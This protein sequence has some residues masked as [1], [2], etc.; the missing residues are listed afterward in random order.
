MKRKVF[1]LAV[2]L[3]LLIP[4]TITLAD[5]T[6]TIVET[7]GIIDGLPTD[8]RDYENVEYAVDGNLST[9]A[10]PQGVRYAYMEWK[11]DEPQD[12]YNYYIS[13]S[14]I[15]NNTRVRF[16]FYSENENG[17]QEL[18]YENDI[19]SNNHDITTIEETGMDSVEDGEMKDITAIRLV[20]S[21]LGGQRFGVA[22]FD[23]NVNHINE[24]K[25][26][27][28]NVN[29]LNITTNTN[30]INLSYTI[31]QQYD[32]INFYVDGELEGTT[33]DSEYTIDRLQQNTEYEIRVT[34]TF[35]DNETEGTTETVRTQ[36]EGIENVEN[37]EYEPSYEYIDLTYDL[38]DHELFNYTSVYV[39]GER[40]IDDYKDGQVT[41][42]GLEDNTTHEIAFK[43]YYED[44]LET[45]EET[46]RIKTLE[47]EVEPG[48]Q[49]VKNLQADNSE[50]GRI[51]LSWDNP[52]YYFD[53]AIIYRKTTS[54]GEQSAFNPFQ[55]YTVHAD[56]T[57]SDHE[58]IFE[59]NGTEFSDLT[60]EEGNEYEYKV[61][62]EYDGIESE[63]V[64][65]QTTAPTPPIIDISD[66]SLPFGAEGLLSSSSAI[67]KLIGSF[68]LLSLA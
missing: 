33:T 61:T 13:A 12:I 9:F 54:E 49:E 29:D 17:E 50:E 22:H 27:L 32:H 20:D 58:P 52:E 65:V 7:D 42:E 53:K 35:G 11:F 15:S 5:E 51:D 39:D 37:I 31:P 24:Q 66:V 67:L 63:G 19:Y 41:V 34:S 48:Q 14:T 47:K 55:T 64:Y 38:P 26:D 43:S 8:Y 36:L 60:V 45:E 25:V 59:T 6:V 40:Y 30:S 46:I 23:V 4:S 2:A 44:D 56:E 21:S 10:E 28:Y 3:M 1:V 68:V 62:T 16:Y 18:V 57:G